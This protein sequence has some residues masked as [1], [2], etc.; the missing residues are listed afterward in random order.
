MIQSQSPSRIRRRKTQKE[1]RE[2][3]REETLE[4]FLELFTVLGWR[5][6]SIWYSECAHFLSEFSQETNDTQ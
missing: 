3:E 5:R 6:H 1:M 4:G 2:K